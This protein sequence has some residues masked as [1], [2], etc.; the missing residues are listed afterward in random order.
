MKPEDAPPRGALFRAVLGRLAPFARLGRERV[1]EDLAR[2]AAASGAAA[3]WAWA[4]RPP[5][6]R[7]IALGFVAAAALAGAASILAQSG[8]PS[9]L[10]ARLDWRAAAAL[11]ERDAR[12]GDAVSLSPPWAERARLLLP[13]GVPAVSAARL[14]DED[15]VG[16][17]RVWLLSIPQAPGFAWDREVELME[18]SARSDGPVPLGAL[19][20]ARYDL[21]VPELPLAF[22]PDRLPAAAARIGEEDCVPVEGALRCGG[23]GV[24]IERTVREVGGVARPCLLVEAGASPRAAIRAAIALAFSAVPVGRAL[25]GHVGVPRDPA[26][27]RSPVRVALAVDGE[28]AGAAEITGGGWT[29]FQID[30]TRFAARQRRVELVLSAPA[31]PSELCLDALTLP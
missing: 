20:V 25:R 3:R 14:A 6:P 11:L 13:A 16:V 29:P 18:R 4:R 7:A 31:W 24:T 22:L 15:L 21:S 8:L 2:I 23:H 30:T 10:P 26:G 9:R 28:E 1:R 5:A 19:E 27:P 17:R 12:P